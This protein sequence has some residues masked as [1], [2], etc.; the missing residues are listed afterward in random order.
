MKKVNAWL[1]R[2]R[3][4]RRGQD[5]IEYALLGAFIAVTVAAFFPTQIA[6]SIMTVFSKVASSLQASPAG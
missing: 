1:L 2:L 4:D 5:M 3:L 6:P